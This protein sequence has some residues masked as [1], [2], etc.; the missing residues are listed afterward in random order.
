MKLTLNARLKKTQSYF[1]RT[2]PLF[3]ILKIEQVQQLYL[4][5]KIFFLRQLYLNPFTRTVYENLHSYY[6]TLKSN[7]LSFFNQ[8]KQIKEEVGVEIT[9]FNSKIVLNLIENKFSCNDQ[10][11]LYD[12]FEIINNFDVNRFYDS[13]KKLDEILKIEF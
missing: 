8:I 6:C 2:R 5:H 11:L 1:C 9:Q 10:D 7:K 4:K 12:L 3:R 13:K